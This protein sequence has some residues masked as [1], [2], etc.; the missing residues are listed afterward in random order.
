[1]LEMEYSSQTIL[2]KKTINEMS[3]ESRNSNLSGRK[4]SR[5]TSFLVMFSLAACSTCWNNDHQVEAFG[6]RK[7]V[8][9]RIRIKS[10]DPERFLADES[11]N[12]D[13][14][15][16]KS[17]QSSSP[18]QVRKRVKAVLEKARTRT[19]VDNASFMPRNVVAGA[20]SIGGFDD[21]VVIE[22]K[23]GETTNGPQ[24]IVSNTL[25]FPDEQLVVQRTNGTETND[26]DRKTNDF[27]VIAGDV[28]AANTFCEPLPFKLP[29]LSTE[30]I[31]L[32]QAGERIQEQ[33]RMGREGSGYVVVDVKAPPYVVWEC[34]LDFEDY[35]VMIPTVKEMQLYT[36]EKLSIGYVNEKPVGPGTGRET[37]HYGIPSITRASFVLSKFRLNIA[38]VHTYT[39]HPEGDYMIFNLDRS[40][41]NMVLK[42]AKGIWHIVANP[43]GRE[44]RHEKITCDP[45]TLEWLT[46]I[47]SIPFSDRN[48]HASTCCARFRFPE[49]FRVLL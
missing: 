17:A 8:S 20:A 49:H 39:P 24:S 42:G 19:G 47:L 27:D 6:V 7:W 38:A 31:R 44:V 36:S 41:T 15:W 32:L 35:P 18:L 46:Q 26:S 3:Y 43:E 23:N 14:S 13:A 29:K 16:S 9:R 5:A 10:S 4:R 48:T 45:L 30:Q 40:C 12:S 2:G 25:V 21:N 28:P 1:M 11:K 33:A 34:L 22:V 37:R